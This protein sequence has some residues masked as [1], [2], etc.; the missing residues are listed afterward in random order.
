M[1]TRSDLARALLACSLAGSL[2]VTANEARAQAAPTK[3]SDPAATPTASSDAPP[4]P[5]DAP[6][7]EEPYDAAEDGEDE[8]EVRIVGDRAAAIQKIPGSFTT[9]RAAEIQAASPQ[10]TA[11]LLRRVPGL[12]VREDTGGGGR[13]DIGIRGLDPGRSR[14]LLVLEDGIPLAINP[15]AEPDL[16]FSPQV[17]R[18]E[19]IEVLKGSGSILYGPQTLG[20]VVNFVTH[21]PPDGLSSFVGV[22]EGEHGYVRTIGRVGHAFPLADTGESVRWL[23]QV[24]FKRT[25]GPR[26]Q[27]SADMD[28]LTKVV[29]PVA[30]RTHATMK[31]AFH[32]GQAQSEDVGL[33]RD[34]FEAEPDHPGLSPA[35]RSLLWRFDGSVVVDADLGDGT[36]LKTLIYA[37]YTDR[38]WRRQLYDRIDDGGP[39]TSVVGDTGLPFGA[40]YFKNQ[41]RVLD[42][43]Y[44]VFGAEPRLTTKFQTG[45]VK[46]TFDAG[47]RVL[48]ET[49]NIEEH[50]ATTAYGS[51]LQLGQIE[52]HTSLGLAAYV[53]DRM[54]FR[55]WLVVTPG[56]RF[57][58][59]SYIRS[60]DLE[61]GE[62]IDV[63]GSDSNAAIIPGL[64]MT[65]GV[66]EAHAFAG[67]H[68]G[69]GPPR[70]TDA[71]SDA[72]AAQLLSPEQSTNWEVGLRVK[73]GEVLVGDATF[74]LNEFSNQVVPN[75]SLDGTTE[76]V[77]GGRTRSVGGDASLTF[78]IG[79][80]ADI[81]VDVDV[82]GRT[83][84]VDARFQSGGREGKKL[85]YAPT[86]TA[87][88]MLDVDTPIGL[89]GSF[90]M[91]YVGEVFSDDANTIRPDASG[92]V[93]LIDAYALLDAGLRFREKTTG[94]GA[95]LAVKNILDRPTVIARR[96]EGIWTT[97]FRQIVL[98]LSYRYDA[99]N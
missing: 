33:P 10:D 13:L 43:A 46:H 77:N 41:A 73:P 16:Y 23:G 66:P 50:L 70:A 26:D 93:G 20:G 47:L 65:L 87:T 37:S 76:L 74:F 96:P 4:A 24:V 22:E 67:M 36:K 78:R 99:G 94:I 3:P 53:Q 71:I 15:Y 90:T 35:S 5:L 40:I 69:Y 1:T 80:A 8:I 29:V 11:E 95:T 68:V 83:S 62:P 79:R 12:F 18:Y 9:V 19:M 44:F 6:S 27:P 17:E 58:H 60:R 34:L 72:G 61:N 63:G 55:E 7:E 52:D 84:L 92:R 28:V 31:V 56:V 89:G 82:T 45:V 30:R 32:R 86:T 59:A 98:G 21:T 57:E 51:E 25:D 64:G 85:P 81:P 75:T 49:A 42:R 48:G 97:G 88:A 54:L 91:N 2:V 14:R 39:Y 38:D